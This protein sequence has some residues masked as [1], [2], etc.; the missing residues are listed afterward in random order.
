[1]VSPAMTRRFLMP[2]WKRWAGL[3]R[4]AGAF[5]EDCAQHLWQ[6]AIRSAT[7]K[8]GPEGMVEHL[9]ATKLKYC[10]WVGLVGDFTDIEGHY[11][12][13]YYGSV[14]EAEPIIDLSICEELPAAVDIEHCRAAGANA[15]V[16]RI[17][18]FTPRRSERDRFCAAEPTVEGLRGLPNARAE[19]D[20][21]L[22][23]AVAEMHDLVCGPHEGV[24][25][26]TATTTATT[27]VPCP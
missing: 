18:M 13:R 15:L 4:D 22:D 25:Q 6:D 27:P 17:H 20:P 19:P 9:A 10:R 12:Q 11:W 8:Q 24:L 21:L 14:F 3:C 23:R 26:P 7:Y 16:V 2:G 5:R 1:M